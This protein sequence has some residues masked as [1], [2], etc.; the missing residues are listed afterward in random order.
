MPPIAA[1][2]CASSVV[3]TCTTV[4]AAV[5]HRRREPGRVADDPAAERD[6]RVAAQQAARART[7]RHSV[8]TV[9]SDLGVLAVAHQ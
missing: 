9:A 4:D 6:D 7:L 5:V 1:S 8:S 2:T 3:G